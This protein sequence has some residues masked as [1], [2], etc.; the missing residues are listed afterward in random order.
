[1][2]LVHEFGHTMGL[3][4]T[5]AS[6]VM[7]TYYTTA[8]TKANPLGDDDIAGISL[9]YPAAQLPVDGGQHLGHGQHERSGR[10]S[11][12]GGCDFAQQSRPL[13]RSPTR[14]A[15]IRSTASSRA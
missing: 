15:R 2:T 4:H 8:S 10:E 12:V 6:S 7:S 5:L 9:L 14:T 13:P 1:M 3:Q 11:G